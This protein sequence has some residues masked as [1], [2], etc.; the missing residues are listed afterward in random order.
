MDLT[1]ITISQQEARI[2]FV[3][4]RHAVRERHQKEDEILMR[5]Y[6]ALALGRRVLS[7][8]DTFIASGF[9]PDRL[10]KLAL[11]RADAKRCDINVDQRGTINMRM[12][13]MSRFVWERIAP[14]VAW[15]A[16]DGN[17]E[18]TAIVPVVPPDLRPAHALDAYHILWEAEWSVKRA[19]KDPALL[20][21]LAGDLFV[22]LAVWNLT[23]LERSVI[24]GT[25]T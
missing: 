3:E 24:L 4:Y 13:D 11:C 6:R 12:A 8:R 17:V 16:P 7:I 22:V 14:S 20:K 9:T 19:P 2:K 23:A 25:R 1:T 15:N 18:A 21:H 5:G 10:P